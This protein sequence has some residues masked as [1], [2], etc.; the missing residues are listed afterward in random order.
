MVRLAVDQDRGL[1]WVDLALGV[2]AVPPSQP[3]LVGTGRS[4]Q[5]ARGVQVAK[6][7]LLAWTKEMLNAVVLSAETGAVR[8]AATVRTDMGECVVREDIG[9][10]NAVDKVI[11]S[12]LRRVWQG[13]QG[14][15]LTSGRIF[16]EMAARL[17]RFGAGSEVSRTAATD[18]AYQLAMELGMGLVGSARSAESLVVYTDGKRI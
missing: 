8:V 3:S 10:H 16:T 17:A 5:P 9:R 1:V 4:I 11:G 12:V 7:Q 14:V 2:E 6:G 13:E 15:I 18:L